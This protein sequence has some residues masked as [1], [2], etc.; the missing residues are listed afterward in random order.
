MEHGDLSSWSVPRIVVVLEGVLVDVD[1]V[2]TKGRFGRT[3]VSGRNWSWLDLPLR[4]MVSMKRRFEIAVDVVTFMGEE[5]CDNAAQFFG[6]HG[7]DVNEVYASDFEEFCW[8]L[9]LRPDIEQVYDS[10]DE[11][12]QRYG[13]RGYSVVKGSVW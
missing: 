4:N 10:D 5:A 6:R 9:N 11:R 12:L 13:Q 3:K 8:G 2:V 1:D 7:I